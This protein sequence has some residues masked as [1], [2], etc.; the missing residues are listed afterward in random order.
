M[1]NLKRT[2]CLNVVADT[3]DRYKELCEEKFSNV[4]REFNL[5]M[6]KE[7]EK[8]RNTPKCL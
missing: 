5:Y 1:K 4:S 8:E 2:T 3:F 7:L 6:L